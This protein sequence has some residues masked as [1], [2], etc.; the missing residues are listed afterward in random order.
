M[1]E[2]SA[3]YPVIFKILYFLTM[4]YFCKTFSVSAERDKASTSPPR[5]VAGT[6]L[7]ELLKSSQKHDATIL[8]Q[9]QNISAD[10][11]RHSPTEVFAQT[12]EYSRGL[13]W[14]Q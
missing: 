14:L 9:L 10:N 13:K 4:P 5:H 7:K 1:S 11:E 2:F 3:K 6:P 8:P 12:E